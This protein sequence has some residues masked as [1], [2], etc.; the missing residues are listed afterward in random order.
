MKTQ[1]LLLPL[2]LAAG[3]LRVVDLDD[4]ENERDAI[5]VPVDAMTIPLGDALVD[6]AIPLPC[7]APQS[8]QATLCGRI[9]DTETDDVVE[10]SNPTRQQCN[11]TTDAGPCSLRIRYFDAIDFAMNPNGAQPLQPQESF[12]DDCGRFRAQNMSR[13]TFGFIA[14]AIDDAPTVSPVEPHR[15]TDVVF[16]NGE[17]LGNPPVRAYTTRVSTDLRWTTTAGLSGSTFAQRGTLLKVYLYHG[18]PQAGVGAT[19]NASQIPADDFYF[20]DVGITRS[21]V[22]PQQ[23]ATGANGSALIINGPTPT[24]HSGTGAEPTGCH[25]PANL[26]V[27]IPGVISVDRK[28]P[29]TTSGAVCP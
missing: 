17:A 12:V 7:P 27:S 16:S 22:A 20:S 19:R 6:C 3:C 8:G 13:A 1:W 2:A 25:W 10:T 15:L 28:E 23:S 9:Y 29:E 14:I 5:V 24:E 21:T 18:V 26:G 4:D 11:G